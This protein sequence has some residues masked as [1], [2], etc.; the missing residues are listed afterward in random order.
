M[1]LQRLDALVKEL[2]FQDDPDQLIRVFAS[3]SDLLLRRDGVVTASCRELPAPQYR[4]LRSWRWPMGANPWTESHLLPLYDHG[5]LGELLYQARPALITPLQVADDDPAREHL[6]GMHS[7][8][9]APAYEQGRPIQMVYALR[10]NSDQFTP[11]ELETLL[12][13]ANL[14]WRTANNLQLTQQLQ[15]AYRRIDH[16]ML[17]VGRMQHHLLPEALPSIEGLELGASY[18]TCSR[19]GG[20]YYDVLPLP[21]GHWGLFM[22]DVSGHGVPAAVVMAMM[23][24]LV[25]AYPGPATPPAQVLAHVNRHLLSIAPEGMFAT[26]F[27]GIYDPPRRRLHY[28]IAGH[29]PPRLRRGRS[30]VRAIE[31]TA[32]LPLGIEYEESWTEREVTLTPGDAL[33]LYTDGI[34][35]G[36]NSASEQFGLARLDDALRLGPWRAG[37]LVQ[38]IERRYRDFCGGTPDMDDR[39]LLAGVAVP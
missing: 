14:L 13:Y 8:A 3:Q 4:I 32:G 27:Y 19:A 2:S 5:L 36:T 39:T 35:E 26:A 6:E 30:H 18:V 25:H 16:E 34:I 24:T 38:H 7:L 22:A 11:D 37:R 10:R 29:P 17:Q 28:A 15:E 1:R 21:D 31:G 23:H 33:L 12:M 20:D 9:C